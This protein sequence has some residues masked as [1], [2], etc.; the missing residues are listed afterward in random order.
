M[1]TSEKAKLIPVLWNEGKSPSEICEELGYKCEKHVVK[2]LKQLGL[3]VNKRV[4]I[5]KVHALQKAGWSMDMI[6]NEFGYQFTA[7]EIQKALECGGQT[8]AQ[9][10]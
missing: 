2:V 8:N 7:E 5:A 6:V 10:D 3:Y 4:D 1:K 9:I